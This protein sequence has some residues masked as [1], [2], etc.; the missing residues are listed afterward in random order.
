MWVVV[1]QDPN[2]S[3]P[4]AL[5]ADAMQPPRP[6]ACCCELDVMLSSNLVHAAY[7]GVKHST[8]HTL[9]HSMLRQVVSKAPPPPRSDR[10]N[11]KISNI[12]THHTH[13]YHATDSLQANLP[14]KTT[15]THVCNAKRCSPCIAHTSRAAPAQS[16]ALSQQQKHH[17]AV[18]MPQCFRPGTSSAQRAVPQSICMHQRHNTVMGCV[19][20][21]GPPTSCGDATSSR[22]QHGRQ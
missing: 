10:S 19:H 6:H 12:R 22:Q 8:I 3:N 4:V 7:Q 20:T 18:M 13:T 11:Q 16:D 14:P 15:P 2:Q 1:V 5:H 9:Q 21:Q 17:G